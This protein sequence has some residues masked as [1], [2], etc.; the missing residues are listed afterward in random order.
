M[1][2]AGPERIGIAMSTHYLML[3][4]GVAIGPVLFGFLI[5]LVGYQGLYLALAGD[6]LAAVVLYWFVHGQ[7][8]SR[9]F[10]SGRR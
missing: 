2:G 3:D 5:P 1:T 7:P 4:A 10:R 8:R 9:W 6:V